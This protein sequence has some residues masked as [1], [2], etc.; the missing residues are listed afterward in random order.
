MKA[1]AHMQQ[2]QISKNK[3]KLTI[4]FLLPIRHKFYLSPKQKCMWKAL[5]SK[6]KQIK[7]PVFSRDIIPE[8][9]LTLWEWNE[10][11]CLD[12]KN[13][14]GSYGKSPSRYYVRTQ[15]HRHSIWHCNIWFRNCRIWASHRTLSA[16]GCHILPK[17]NTAHS[18]AGRA[19]AH[20][21]HLHFVFGS[22]CEFSSARVVI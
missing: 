5:E 12:N 9:N 13:I 17:W 19:N 16:W 21:H 15:I 2:E 1:G 4:L 3:M 10:R 11:D 18:S 8:G 20:L 6:G 22:S 14:P 7:N